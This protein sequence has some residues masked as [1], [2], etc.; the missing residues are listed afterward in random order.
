ML[1]R[2]R[3]QLRAGDTTLRPALD[4]LLRVAALARD[5]TPVAVTDKTT[6]LPPSGDRHDYF[7]LSPYWW[8]DPGKPAG[9]PYIR[10]DGETNSESKRDLDQ[11]RVATLGRICASPSSSGG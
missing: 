3:E 1:A 5:A 11:P 6:L 8:P 2:T 10:R 4:K 9:L 7:S